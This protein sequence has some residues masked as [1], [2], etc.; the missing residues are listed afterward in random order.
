MKWVELRTD[1]FLVSRNGKILG[2][3][4]PSIDGS[5]HHAEAIYAGGGDH[6]QSLGDYISNDSA[7][8]AVEQ[9]TKDTGLADGAQDE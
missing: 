8:R 6:K 4:S 2:R 3:V 5:I 9:S 7:R 1:D